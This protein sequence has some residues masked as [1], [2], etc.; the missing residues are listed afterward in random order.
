MHASFHCTN[1][2]KAWLEAS[3]LV[4]QICIIQAWSN[5]YIMRQWLETYRCLF[6]GLLGRIF[7]L[8]LRALASP[9]TSEVEQISWKLQWRVF[10]CQIRSPLD[11]QYPY[12]QYRTY[13]W[14]SCLSDC[15]ARAYVPVQYS[16]VL[17][18]LPCKCYRTGILHTNKSVIGAPPL[19]SV[20]KAQLR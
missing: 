4:W 20:D 7:L 12:V 10:G 17:Y 15:C 3:S 19:N 14:M 2:A 16:Y 13:L 9:E 18:A 5:T 11:L 8:L 6:C 1:D